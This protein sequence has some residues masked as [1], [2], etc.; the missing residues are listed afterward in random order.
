MANKL[1]LADAQ[2]LGFAIGKHEPGIIHLVECMGLTL[3]EWEKWKKEYCTTIL[4]YSEKEEI[5]EYFSS[6]KK[7]KS[8]NQ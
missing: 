5:E 3:K 8:K 4:T 6:N 2:F 7:Q 1:D